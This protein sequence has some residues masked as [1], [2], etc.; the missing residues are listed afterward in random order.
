M[1]HLPQVPF[2]NHLSQAPFI[3][4]PPPMMQRPPLMIALGGTQ[5]PR[6]NYVPKSNNTWAPKV[7]QAVSGPRITK[8]GNVVVL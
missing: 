7:T 2:M 4:Y 1:N 5:V 6:A 3:A 8:S